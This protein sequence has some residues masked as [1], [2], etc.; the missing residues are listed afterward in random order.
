M[1]NLERKVVRDEV[2]VEVLGVAE[3]EGEGVGKVLKQLGLTSG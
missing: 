2:D 1:D 3:D